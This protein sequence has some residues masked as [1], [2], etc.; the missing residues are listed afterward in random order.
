MVID[1]NIFIE[2]IRAKDKS[3]TTLYQL[4][5]DPDLHVSA[6][7]VYELFIGATSKQKEIESLEIIEELHLLSFDKAAAIK[8]GQIYRNLKQQ[9]KLIEFRDIFIAAICIVNNQPLATLN[10]KHF[11]RIGKLKLVDF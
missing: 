3:H 9:N 5:V 11:E 7:S 10:K 2:H 1:T 6:V 8:A 4:S